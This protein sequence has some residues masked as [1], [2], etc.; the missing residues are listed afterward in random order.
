MTRETIGNHG[1]HVSGTI[2][3][4]GLDGIGVSGLSPL[5][6][7]IGLKLLMTDGTGVASSALR[8]FDYLI[9]LK[10]DQGIPI[11]AVNASWRVDAAEF[12][13]MLYDAVRALGDN[14]ILLVAA[15]GN[16]ASD[17]DAVPHHPASFD[18]PNVIS[19]AATDHNDGLALFASPH[20]GGSNW[21]ALGV[22]VAAPGKDILS[23]TPGRSYNLKTGTSMAAPHVTGLVALVAAHSPALTGLQI[24][25]RILSTVDVLPGL[26]G[27]I[28]T[29]GRINAWRAL[30]GQDVGAPAVEV[31][32]PNGGEILYGGEVREIRWAADDDYQLAHVDVAWSADGGTSFEDIVVGGPNVGSLSWRVPAAST[33]SALLRVR[34][35]D[36][37]GN[38]GYD[39]SDSAF[40]VAPGPPPPDTSSPT[41]DLLTPNGGESLTGG[42]SANIAWRAIDDVGVVRVDL[43][44]SFD[45]RGWSWNTIATGLPNS[46][47]HHWQVPLTS[48]TSTRV[49][50]T[51]WDAAGNGRSDLSSSFFTITPRPTQPDTTPP[52]VTVL[53]PNG[54]ETWRAGETRLLTW[55]AR[56]NNV[57]ASANVFYSLNGGASWTLATSGL[58][59][60]SSYLLMVPEVATPSDLT[61]VKVEVLDAASNRANDTSDAAFRIQPRNIPPTASAGADQTVVVGGTVVLDGSGSSDPDDGIASYQWVQLSGPAVTLSD[62]AA[63]RPT[64]VAP[65]LV[66]VL[67]L[68]LTVHD[69]AGQAA[70]AT[71]RVTVLDPAGGTGSIL[72][73]TL[74][75]TGAVRKDVWVQVRQLSS[76]SYQASAK[77]DYRGEAR[78]GS[79]YPGTY[80]VGRLGSFG[81]TD[82]RQVEVGGGGVVVEYRY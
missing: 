80:E 46:G 40:S 59:A 61:L 18:L 50:V 55:A 51:A 49:R 57:V 32:S 41:V 56:D 53:Q 70:A 38:R 69:A 62:P 78:F 2:G 35:E 15:A 43:Q 6:R 54:G 36:A 52:S 82:K 19:V 25:D 76:G 42:D 34:A 21:G 71:T 16:Q 73:R 24:K 74:T 14:D 17:D 37:D 11:R 22:D 66:G 72:V 12:P 1:T 44:W 58:S 28:L 9:R 27:M 79:L 64:F 67:S 29:G 39:L 3:A 48:S 68:Q 81:H 77:T 8:A 7:I 63:V 30:G 5:V 4:T 26:Q 60:A 10:R 47:S 75:K 20:S 13:Q 33:S 23:T 65:S 31:V 45:S